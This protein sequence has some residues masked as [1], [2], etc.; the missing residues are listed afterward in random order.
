M[1]GPGAAAQAPR[2]Q[3]NQEEVSTVLAALIAAAVTVGLLV[4]L[5]LSVH[6]ILKDASKDDD[7][8]PL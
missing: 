1:P 5:G 8:R 4:P 2:Q 3:E 7:W 6:R